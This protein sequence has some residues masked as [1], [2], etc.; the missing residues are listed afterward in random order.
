MRRMTQGRAGMA[1][2]FVLGLVIATAGSATAARL[3]TGKQI[4]DGSIAKRD[5]TRALRV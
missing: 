2:T 4:K 5:L 3:I 1:L